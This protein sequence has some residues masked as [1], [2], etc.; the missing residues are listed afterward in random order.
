MFQRRLYQAIGDLD[1]I[2]NIAD[3]VLLYGVGETKEEA[4][5]DHDEKLGAFLTRCQTVGIRLNPDK[6]RVRH[7][8]RE[9]VKGALLFVKTNDGQRIKIVTQRLETFLMF[10]GIYCEKHSG[11]VGHLMTYA[12]IVQCIA[13]SCGDEAAIE[14]DVN[15]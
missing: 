2:L 7:R 15:F 13:K 9:C 5:K 12:Q 6:M 11:E 1:G 8:I 3:D 10:V 4:T 14:Y